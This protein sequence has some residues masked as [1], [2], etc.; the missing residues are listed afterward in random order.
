MSA[1]TLL[2]ATGKEMLFYDGKGHLGGDAESC[3]CFCSLPDEIVVLQ[4][5][6]IRIELTIAGTS[7]EMWYDPFGTG[8]SWRDMPFLIDFDGF[9]YYQIKPLYMGVAAG[10]DINLMKQSFR[11]QG[12]SSPAVYLF[13]FGSHYLPILAD[14]SGIDNGMMFIDHINSGVIRGGGT[15]QSFPTHTGDTPVT[16][17]ALSS[18][19]I[20]HV[21]YNGSVPPFFPIAWDGNVT[22][23]EAVSMSG[24]VVFISQWRFVNS[25][26]YFAKLT[27]TTGVC[28]YKLQIYINGNLIWQ[29][30]KLSYP[31]GLPTG[32]Y[33]A[34]NPIWAV[35]YVDITD[36]TA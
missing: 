7:M 8:G 14:P 3:C 20:L 32:H 26:V 1:Y 22:R 18:Y 30:L 24:Q 11:V 35:P 19:A 16:A 27:L 28:T 12:G 10:Q 33:V 15:L 21:D 31:D 9:R 5:P 34:T 23:D 25:N 17:Y 36:V 2:D 13:Y 4:N 6:I 29:G